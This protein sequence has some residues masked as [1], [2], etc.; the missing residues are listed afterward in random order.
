MTKK[1]IL[2]FDLET[3]EKELLDLGEK[4][5]RAHQIFTWIHQKNVDAFIECSNVQKELIQLLDENYKIDPMEIVEKKVSTD[6]TIK[7]LLKLED[8]NV[9]E[10]VVMKYKYGY[11][12]CIS[13]QAGCK[14]GCS[15]CASTKAGYA[16]DLTAGEMLQQVYI[17]QKDLGE[18][19]G[20]V[21]V[22]GIGEPLD[23]YNNL[24]CFLK[25]LISPKGSNLGA[26][27]ITVSTCGLVEKIG[28]LAEERLQVNLA[29]SLHAPNDA[30]RKKMM[31]IAKKYTIKEII[32]V[33]Q[34]YEKL[35]NRRINFE[36]ALIA[37]VND[38]E[39]NARELARL[40]KDLLCF[41]NLIPVNE[42]TE[43]EY[44]KS[45]KAQIERFAKILADYKIQSTIRRELGTDIRAACGQ[46]RSQYIKK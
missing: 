45:S 12:I 18:R 19:I 35:N 10:S 26:R 7:Y 6:G 25:N 37:G 24:I 32:E 28:E 17:A 43:N 2:S 30:I 5:Y 34:Y 36:Y 14:M 3:L 29:V 38:T 8:G 9:I 13:S 23:N 40:L 21:V 41:V 16:R 4:K 27:H 31:P 46:L 22:M 42:I 33:C 39:E 1:S 11:S 44:K 20:N 15:F